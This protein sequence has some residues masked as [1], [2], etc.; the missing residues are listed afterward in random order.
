MIHF[1]FG[2]HDLKYLD[3]KG[4]YVS[5]AQGRQVAK[6]DQYE[7]NLRKVVARL[8]QTGAILVWAST[9]PVPEGSAGR[10][11]GDEVVYNAVAKKVMDDNGVLIDDLCG[12]LAGRVAELQ[13]PKN[14]HFSDQGSKLLADSVTASI[15]AALAKPWTPPGP[16]VPPDASH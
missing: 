4:K 15:K 1:N 5:P 16:K 6:P 10:V 3:E 9:T 11:Q 14:V 8:K 2:L 13:K 12:V 7:A